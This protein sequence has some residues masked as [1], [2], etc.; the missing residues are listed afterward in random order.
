MKYWNTKIKQIKQKCPLNWL[1]FLEIK[2]YTE[3]IHT[4]CTKAFLK[5]THSFKKK[6]KKTQSLNPANLSENKT[7][8]AESIVSADK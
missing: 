5:G 7:V 2:I 1:V 4:I 6:K 3:N 8:L